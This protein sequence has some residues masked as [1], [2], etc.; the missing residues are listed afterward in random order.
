MSYTIGQV[1]EKMGVTT[2]TLRYYEKE[3]L[4]PFVERTE[5]GIRSFKDSDVECLHIIECLKAT[6]MPIKDIK[7]F[8]D[9]CAEGDSTLQQRYEMFLERRKEVLQQMADLQ[10]TLATIEYKC[11]YYKDA[12]DALK[13]TVKS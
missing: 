11:Q 9:W 7:V 3:G 2:H 5:S 13:D 12:L 10:R 4:L 8:I 6:G 1:A